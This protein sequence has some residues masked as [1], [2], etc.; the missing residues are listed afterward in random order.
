MDSI[1]QAALGATLAGAVAGK[2]LG[3]TA[4]LVGAV[5]GT[6][7][8]LDVVIDYGT[9]IANFTQHRGFSHSLLVLLPLSLVL[10][11]GLQHWK[12]ELSYR[13]WCLLTTL[14]LVTHPL[15]DTFTTYGTQIF[16]PFGSP[17]ALNSIFIIDPLYTLPLLAAILVFLFRPHAIQALV[18]GLVL[19]TA[20][21]GWS[22]AAQ[23]LISARVEPALA[24][25][26]LDQTP[27]LVQPMPFNTLLWRVT[28]VS[29]TQRL[30][31]VTGFLDGDI[32][33]SIERFP[34]DPELARAASELPEG[35]RLAWFTR[36]F[37]HYDIVEGRLT[38]TDI[39][40]GLPGAHPFTFILAE[41]NGNGWLVAPSYQ[42]A[43][44]ALR[45]EML[46]ALWARLTGE[47][48]VLCLATLDTPPL[49]ES[50]S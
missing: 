8:D 17:V 10:A 28:V 37:L 50:C 45:P 43:R 3:R 38:A 22:L 20:Y 15:L 47:A 5:L 4:L 32:P 25:E 34:R 12:P 18:A 30:E 11:W 14:V 42:T 48:P 27:R 24:A 36:G 31:V 49:G 26:G 2:T 1:T 39:R 44:P 16:W 40:L 41:N 33:L 9:A 29:D 7:P 46:S 23:Q 6:L 13:R 35:R 19:S 21:L